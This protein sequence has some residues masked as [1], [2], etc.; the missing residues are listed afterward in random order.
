MQEIISK[1]EFNK[2]MNIEGK[3]R[4][5]GL[6]G[7]AKFIL[8]KEGKEGLERLENTIT[9]LG[10]P[11][12]YKAIAAT[13]FYPIGL[14]VLT[15]LAAKRLFNYDS[16]IFQEIGRFIAKYPLTV[17]IFIS[18]FS[19]PEKVINKN[20]E[21]W[22]KAFTIGKIRIME[23]NLEEKYMTM[24]LENFNVHP[25]LCQVFLG[26][27]SA[28]AQMFIKVK[29]SCEETKCVHRGDD[30]HEFLFKEKED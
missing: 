2:L 11:L 18:Y 24:R 10:Y 27:L 29:V 6:K 3:A 26:S 9:N 19:S 14:E 16:E 21:L 23:L 5:A 17:R 28:I 12:K 30:Y 7:E 22:R 1:E 15:L 20:M 25:L 4:G 8:E 13:R